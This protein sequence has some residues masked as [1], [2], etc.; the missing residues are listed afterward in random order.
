MVN[1]TGFFLYLT[2]IVLPRPTDRPL[3]LSI[4]HLDITNEE[5]AR[6]YVL[7]KDNEEM[8]EAGLA[9]R[10][11]SQIELTSVLAFGNAGVREQ[12]GRHVSYDNMTTRCSTCTGEEEGG[13]AW[14]KTPC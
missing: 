8:R 2:F 12:C 6:G 4:T 14:W 7:L 13:R 1:L 5:M 3:H 11:A 9:L 10:S